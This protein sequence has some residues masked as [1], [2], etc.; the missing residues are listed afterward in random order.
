MPTKIWAVGEEVLAADFNDY[1]QEQVVA[2]FPNAAARAAA[3]TAP[4]PGMLTYLADVGRLEQ[5]TDKASPVGWYRPWGQPW[6]RLQT[7]FAPD[8]LGVAGAIF[9]PGMTAN[10]MGVANRRYEIVA[11]GQVQKADAT[12]GTGAFWLQSAGTPEHTV[13]ASMQNLAGWAVPLIVRH[14]Y[15]S[16]LQ[17]NVGASCD[18]GTAHFTQ[19]ILTVDDVGPV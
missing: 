6:G 1:V 3:I 10:T 5:Y 15:G 2:T 9:L 18:T 13:R 11:T 12:I 8:A 7:I 17:V 4:I 16:T 19:L 14:T